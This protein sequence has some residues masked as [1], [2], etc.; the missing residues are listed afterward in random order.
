MGVGRSQ[1]C[2]GRLVRPAGGRRQGRG[3]EVLPPCSARKRTSPLA[4]RRSSAAGLVHGTRKNPAADPGDG[5]L[6]SGDAGD[7]E[8]PI[9]P[10]PRPSCGCVW[11]RRR[12][13]GRAL[14]DAE[15]PRAPSMY[16]T[17]SVNT[18]PQPGL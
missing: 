15:G 11:A 9:A 6:D 1:S 10:D 8:G 18:P 5:G 4:R 2:G 16:C 13:Q 17:G 14:L 12:P 7:A 3:T